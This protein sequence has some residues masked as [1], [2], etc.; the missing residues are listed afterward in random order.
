MET[1]RTSEWIGQRIFVRPVR[2]DDDIGLMALY[3]TLDVDDRYRRFFSAWHPHLEF[4]ADL[5]AAAERGGARF[6]AVLHDRP[7]AEDRIIGEAGY[8][9]LP[10]GDGELEITVERGWQAWLGP[11]LLEVL[12]EFAAASGVPNLEADVLTVNRPLLALLRSRGSVAMAHEGWSVVRLLIG[13]ASR[14]AT[15]PGRHD[16]PRL[17]V[18]RAGGR[19]HAEDAARAAG[20]DVLICAG[21]SDEARECPLLGGEPCQLATEADAIVVSHPL[22]DDRWRALLAGQTD[23]HP[24]V[25]VFVETSPAQPAG[26]ADR[27]P[28]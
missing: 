10:N 28:N 6:V 27:R 23:A 5:A 21:P 18:E 11:Y 12:V 19:W 13:T 17:L 14:T 25:P 3:E 8:N 26:L 4:F 22:C 16:R 1:R 24:G 9:L 15:W 7:T 2:P 20:L